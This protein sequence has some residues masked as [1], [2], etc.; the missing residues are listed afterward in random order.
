MYLNRLVHNYAETY[1]EC[2]VIQYITRR[3]HCVTWRMM[4]LPV[5]SHPLPVPVGSGHGCL[6]S[7]SGPLVAWR[8]WAAATDP[9]GRVQRPCCLLIPVQVSIAA[10]FSLYISTT[11]PIADK[12]SGVYLVTMTYTCHCLLLC[13]IVADYLPLYSF[14][15]SF[16]VCWLI[17]RDSLPKLQMIYLFRYSVSSLWTGYDDI[18]CFGFVHLDTVF[19]CC[20]T[21][22]VDCLHYTVWK[23]RC[24]FV[25]WVNYPFIVIFRVCA[26][27]WLPFLWFSLVVVLLFL[28]R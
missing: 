10:I 16:L 25:I 12:D 21:V 28:I 22:S 1:I 18:P 2:D 13:H 26:L 19:K 6:S 15:L 4:S 9:G 23:P 27:W 5:V 8:E 7:V 14:T 3:L 11:H 20:H 24:N 17:K